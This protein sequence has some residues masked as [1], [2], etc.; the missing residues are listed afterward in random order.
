M[1]LITQGILGAATAQ[2]GA[3]K[4][5]GKIATAIG[6]IA[7]MIPDIDSFIQHP[8][9]P[10]FV[11][12]Y[13][14]HFTHSLIFIPFAAF[15][16]AIITHRVLS[17]KIS[18]RRLFYYSLLGICLAALL[19]AC[20]SYGT[21]LLWPFS[22]ERIAWNIIAIVDP[23]FT[24]L[25][26]VPL[27]FGLL[28]NN[29]AL[30]RI[31]LIVAAS[32]L[33]LATVQSNRAYDVAEEMIL[34][35]GHN[36]ERLLVKPTL[37]NILLWR[38]IYSSNNE[39]FVDAIRV[40]I[41]ADNKIYNGSSLPLLDLKTMNP[42]PENTRGR[43]DLVRFAKLSNNWLAYDPS[44]PDLVGDIRYAMLPTSTIP[45]WGVRLALSQ[46]D[47]HMNF[48][49]NRNFTREMRHDFMSMLLGRTDIH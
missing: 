36:A 49:T 39:I 10:L 14:R 45:L 48:E 33:G 15:I 46:P 17:K 43:T 3:K 12:E 9:D 22:D 20:T 1:D 5:E 37:G 35:R 7:G 23:V 32:Y 18:I 11:L 24:L 16:L 40:G 27:V 44:Q 26:F 21:H 25:L 34:N 4:D 42:Y 47:K 31:G 30:S 6:F 8:E 38:S 28:K 41:I 29:P 19:D 2:A 13:H